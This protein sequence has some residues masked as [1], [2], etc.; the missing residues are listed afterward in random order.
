[1]VRTDNT[2]I[3][4]ERY[5]N[6]LF[7]IL[8]MLV[9][10]WQAIYALIGFILNRYLDFSENV[11]MCNKIFKIV[12]PSKI[13]QMNNNPYIRNKN[14]PRNSTNFIHS[15]KKSNIE[16]LVLFEGFKYYEFAGLEFNMME[17]FLHIFNY[18][19]YPIKSKFALL[20]HATQH[21]NNFKDVKNLFNF[22]IHLKEFLR[23]NFTKNQTYIISNFLNK[24]KFHQK[25]INNFKIIRNIVSSSYSMN[26]EEDKKLERKEILKNTLNKFRKR[27]RGELNPIDEKLLKLL[28]IEDNLLEYFVY[29]EIKGY[30]IDKP[31]PKNKD[32][33][34]GAKNDFIVPFEASIK[35]ID[36]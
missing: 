20:E 2:I 22:A 27:K 8:A 12:D 26:D 3:M 11:E 31:S 23:F 28:R 34:I 6:T 36:K 25:N 32:Q 5:Y 33:L 4:M 9:G 16:E 21:Y 30:D 35:K 24:T 19:P 15:I 13:E 10:L 18:H 7:L 14:I 29:N 17:T 1:V